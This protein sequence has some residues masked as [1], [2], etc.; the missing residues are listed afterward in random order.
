MMKQWAYFVDGV[1]Y[2]VIDDVVDVDGREVPLSERYHPEF[3]EQ[4]VPYVPPVE[5]GET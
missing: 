2:E 4:L 5:G 1:L 3:V